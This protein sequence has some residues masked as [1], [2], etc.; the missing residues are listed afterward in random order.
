MENIVKNATRPGWRGWDKGK[1]LWQI[2]DGPN[3]GGT[4]LSASN[5]ER[6]LYANS[7]EEMSAKLAETSSYP[8][9][10]TFPT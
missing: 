3:N 5:G 2:S 4:K 6:W 9:G 8:E 10:R 7:L 1:R